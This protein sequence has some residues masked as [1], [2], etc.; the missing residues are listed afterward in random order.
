MELEPGGHAEFL[1]G[2]VLG[3]ALFWGL[4]WLIKAIC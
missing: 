1:I 3:Y 4:L 2:V